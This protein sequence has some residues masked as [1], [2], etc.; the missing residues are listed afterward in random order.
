MNKRNSGLLFIFI[1]LAL[2]L[3]G[4]FIIGRSLGS[5]QTVSG[6]GDFTDVSK[7][8]TK[9][10]TIK[11]IEEGL[12]VI[13]KKYVDRDNINRDDLL[14]GAMSGMLKVLEDDYSVFLE[15]E[16]TKTFEEDVG[17]SFEGIGAEIGIRDGMLTVISP[18]KDN[19]ADRAGVK[20][21]D[22]ILYVDGT[23]TDGLPLDEAVQ[24]IRGRKGSAVVL[25]IEREGEEENL[26]ISIV[27]DTI[28]IP[29]IEWEKKGDEIAYIAFSHFTETAPGDF[30]NIVQEI[31]QSSADRVILDLRN[32]PG[33]F[34]EVAVDITGWFI[35]KDKV[36]VIEERG[37]GVKNKLYMSSGNS[38]M[39]EYPIV[40]LI[41]KGSASASEILAGA[42]RDH[43]G[44]V[45]IG[46]NTFGKGSVQELVHLRD[47]SSI[48]ITIAKWLTPD[49]LSIED[50]GLEPDIAVE[51]TQ[52]I[53][54]KQGDV[55]LEKAI[56][57]VEGL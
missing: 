6:M 25:T 55:Q 53:F 12:D 19:P 22:K 11:L 36:V 44:V 27:R 18:L 15:P 2:G 47:G 50:N 24:I 37:H 16:D 9:K 10:P 13:A 49:G 52:E 3:G 41:N 20:A 23:D 32:N 51:M 39:A 46:E 28:K 57:V 35:E 38:A 42:L 17:G 7:I 8:F 40:I 43:K 48:K 1:V 21:G 34:L 56:E 5:N 4:G 54:D 14:Y 29:I 31:L 45:L 33:G 26:E 30:E